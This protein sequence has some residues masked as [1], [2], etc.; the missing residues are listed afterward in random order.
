MIEINLL[1]KELQV[2]GSR[3][4]FSRA[5]VAPAVA[6]VVMVV[7]MAGMTF[8][9]K[10]Q[11]ADLEGKIRIAQARAE[12]LKRDIQMVD[13][14]VEIKE[15]ITARIDAVK[16]LDRNR[17]AWVNIM[18]DLASRIPEFL[19][20][21]AVREMQNTPATTPG[22]ADSARAAQPMVA[23]VPTEVEGY[24]YSL[25]GLANLIIQL[26]DS[27]HFNNVDLKHARE[28]QLESHAAYSFALSCNL[29]YAGATGALPGTDTDGPSELAQ[30]A[31]P[32]GQQN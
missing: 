11:I 21:T 23:Q 4:V 10:K 12:Q 32:I 26:R 17:N 19:W 20:V 18:E 30:A 22:A 1:P 29:D 25:S 5:L 16:L 7:G 9:Q 6:A 15:K 27:G 13:A 31:E 28:V 14:L 8:Y 3:L 24:A 2:R